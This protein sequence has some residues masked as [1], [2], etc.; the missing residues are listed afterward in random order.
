MA[1]IRYNYFQVLFWVKIEKNFAKNV[2]I[3]YSF[4]IYKNIME[5]S[6]N[7]LSFFGCYDTIL[8]FFSANVS[9]QMYVFCLFN[10]WVIP[11][12][13]GGFHIGLIVN[14]KLNLNFITFFMNRFRIFKKLESS[15][16]FE[17]SFVYKNQDWKQFSIQFSI[18]CLAKTGLLRCL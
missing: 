12:F 14:Q 3:Q 1:F 10:L 11:L 18:F 6:E 2:R 4:Y 8:T 7:D 13:F 15:V 9:C 16:V 17:T 5:T